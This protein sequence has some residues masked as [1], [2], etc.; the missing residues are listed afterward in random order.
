MIWYDIPQATE[1]YLDTVESVVKHMMPTRRARTQAV[2]WAPDASWLA[3]AGRLARFAHGRVEDAKC[4]PCTR[5]D[6]LIG[7]CESESIEA[8]TMEQMFGL[9]FRGTTN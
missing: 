9:D 4:R 2:A 6:L 8:H 5:C 1:G 3:S 7:Y